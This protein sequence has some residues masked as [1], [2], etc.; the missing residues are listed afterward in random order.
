MGYGRFMATTIVEATEDLIP[1]LVASVG[2]LFAEDGARH[3]PR[4]DADWPRRHGAEYYG[5]LRDQGDLCLLARVDGVPAGHLVGRL[6]TSDIRPGA[7]IAALESMQ[8]FEPF[9]RAGV[10]SALVAEFFAWADRS[11]VTEFR[12]TAFTANER[13]IAFYRAHGFEPFEST[14]HR[15]TA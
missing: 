5:P 6:R 12:V 4:M 2:A 10:G 8:V 15:L 7:R 14:L 9:R 1:E 11:D 3:D 13:A